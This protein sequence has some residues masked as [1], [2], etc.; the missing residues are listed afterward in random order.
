MFEGFSCFEWTFHMLKTKSPKLN[1]NGFKGGAF[2][3]DDEGAAFV[4]E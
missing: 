4:D 3:I 2:G 1:A